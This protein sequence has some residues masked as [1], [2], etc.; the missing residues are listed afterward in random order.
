MREAETL[1][2]SLDR[3]HRLFLQVQGYYSSISRLNFV[4]SEDLRGKIFCSCD[5]GNVDIVC[6]SKPPGL[7]PI[8]G[9][10]R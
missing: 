1:I 4:P 8:E 3:C 7:L 6:Q 2:E 10:E 9:P 5:V